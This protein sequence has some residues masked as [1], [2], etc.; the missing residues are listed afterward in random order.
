VHQCGSF[1]GL[2]VVLRW[3]DASDEVFHHTPLLVLT[4][5][6]RNAEILHHIL[7]SLRS[8]CSVARDRVPAI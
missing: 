1:V 8:C 3:S 7:Y 6:N 2:T 4:V 5:L